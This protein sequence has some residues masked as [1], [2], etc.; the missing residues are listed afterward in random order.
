MSGR[1]S[2]RRVAAPQLAPD[3][4]VPVPDMAMAALAAPPVEDAPSPADALR[5]GK[6]LD[7]KVR[8]HRKLLEEINLAAMEKLPPDEV[9][10]LRKEQTVPAGSSTIRSMSASPVQETTTT[11]S[12]IM[13]V[14][15]EASKASACSPSFCSRSCLRVAEAVR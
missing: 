14:L 8:L 7:A 10:G 9:R 2:L 12:R 11:Q 6:V 1:F 5:S 3:E 4:A 13:A 15:S